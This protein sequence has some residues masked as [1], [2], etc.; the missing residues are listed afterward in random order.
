MPSQYFDKETN[1]HYNY[2]RDYDSAI[3]GYVESDPIG[4]EGG[5]N[6]YGYVLGNPLAYIDVTGLATIYGGSTGRRNLMKQEPDQLQKK[7]QDATCNC[8]EKRKQLDDLFDKWKIIMSEQNVPRSSDGTTAA[9][10]QGRG[11][12]TTYFLDTPI[13][14]SRIGH[15]Y[16]HIVPRNVKKQTLN[17]A[18]KEWGDRSYETEAIRLSSMIMQGK[19]ICSLLTGETL[20]SSPTPDTR[21]VFR[22]MLGT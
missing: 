21:S 20:P 1:T 14:G 5:I 2:Y 3:G 6:T 11:L 8:P 17:E 22:R 7:I 19:D 9:E 4:L 16:I 13:T 12:Q 10:T 15:E 18:L